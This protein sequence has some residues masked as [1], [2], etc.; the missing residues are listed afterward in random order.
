MP[1]VVVKYKNKRALNALLD[2]AKYFDFSVVLPP[3]KSKKTVKG[4]T[5]LSS[6]NSVD[7]HDL[8]SIFSNRDLSGKQLRT[9]AWQRNK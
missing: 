1:E 2:F 6:D 7:V 4:V 8:E 5:V 3:K 9:E